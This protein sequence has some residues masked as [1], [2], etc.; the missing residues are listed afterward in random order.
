[1]SIKW[2]NKFLQVSARSLLISFYFIEKHH[3]QFFPMDEFFE[4]S[5]FDNLFRVD[6]NSEIISTDEFPHQYQRNKA[7]ITLFFKETL[8]FSYSD[9]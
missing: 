5:R 7:G 3:P 2:R 8:K 4:F 9:V 1:M 6:H